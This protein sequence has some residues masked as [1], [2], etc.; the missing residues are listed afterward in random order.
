[1]DWENF[2]VA[3]TCFVSQMS[4]ENPLES[5]LHFDLATV[6]PTELL[7]TV[8]KCRGSAVSIKITG[9]NGQ[10]F[11]GA[12][13][14][15]INDV[16]VQ[17]TIGDF[18]FCSFGD[19]DT[20]VEGNVGSFFGHSIASGILVVRGHARHAVGALGMNGLIAILGNAGDRAALGM[21]GAD[22]VVRGS[23]ANYA[24]LGMQNGTLI[25]GGA[26][27]KHLGH[28]MRGG[29]IYLRGEAES[30]SSDVEEN[31]LREPDRLKIGMLMLKSNIKSAG[32]EFRV[33]RPVRD[34]L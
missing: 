30:I 34:E 14:R 7:N 28:G 15:D 27:G 32:K 23:V 21:H 4:T 17:G 20:Q 26:S 25:V 1:M 18:G 33:F 24:G 11:V 3:H 29:T 12:G 8:R 9:A 2:L 19:G 16:I 6:S 31:R 13:L 10:D 5:E 22:V